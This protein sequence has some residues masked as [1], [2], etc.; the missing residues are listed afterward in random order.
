MFA[1]TALFTGCGGYDPA[2]STESAVESSA[3]ALDT[4]PDLVPHSVVVT[5]HDDPT[6]IDA[7]L[8]ITNNRNVAV[9]APFTVVFGAPPPPPCD[10]TCCE[11]NPDNTCAYC[12]SGN[13]QCP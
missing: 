3:E 9:T 1:P 13:Q 4:L 2:V 5:D 11:F 10:G 6:V 8:F 12:I 7:K